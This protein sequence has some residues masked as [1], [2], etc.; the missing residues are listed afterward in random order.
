[1]WGSSFL[2]VSV[3]PDLVN[4]VVTILENVHFIVFTVHLLVGEIKQIV[5]KFVIVL[6]NRAVSC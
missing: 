1:M 2:S 6:L 4:P 5:N 3:G